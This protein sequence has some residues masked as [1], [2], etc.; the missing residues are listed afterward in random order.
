MIVS[1]RHRIL[2]PAALIVLASMIAA[3]SSNHNNSNANKLSGAVR[4]AVSTTATSASSGAPPRT[5]VSATAAASLAGPKKELAVQLNFIPNVEH[6][7]INYAT[8]DGLYDKQ[9]LKVTVLPGGQGVDPVQVVAAGKALIGVSSPSA[10][11]TAYSQGIKLKAFAVEFQKDPTALTC[12]KDSGVKVIQDV[13]GKKVGLKALASDAFDV[14]LK[15]NNIDKSKLDIVP[16]GQSS[17]TEIIAGTIQCQY[18]TFA[19]NEPNSMRKNGVEPVVM[20][21]ADNGLPSQGNV[22]FTSADQ[23][24]KNKDILARW[25]KATQAAWQNFLAD[26]TAAAKYVVDKAFV[27]G[28]DIDQQT[29]QAVSQ[30]DLLSSDLTKSKGL[31]WLD[32]TLWSGTAQ[33]IFNAKTTPTLV[34]PTAVLTTEIL[35]M[36]AKA[37]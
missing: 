14:L 27:D 21:A 7:A 35:E 22:Y 19:V 29:A 26:P 13:V 4:Q 15:K 16:I 10:I 17:V 23:Y 33:D 36:A 9:N 3:C 18:S 30:A 25:V 37:P 2:V 20:L 34:D 5:T 31:L 24:E 32:P 12:R 28:L 1:Q 6:Y 8:K 11:L